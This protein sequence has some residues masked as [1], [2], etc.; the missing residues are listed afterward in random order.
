MAD[1]PALDGGGSPRNSSIDA[2]RVHAR[3]RNACPCEGVPL[4]RR[5]RDSC[6]SLNGQSVRA[7]RHFANQHYRFTCKLRVCWRFPRKFVN[8]LT[9]NSN[10]TFTYTPDTSFTGV[11]FFTYTI[12]DGTATSTLATARITVGTG[13]SGQLNG[14]DLTRISRDALGSGSLT[15]AQPLGGGLNLVYQS[16]TIPAV[17]VPVETFLTRGTTI[18]NSA[19]A[20]L[21][22]GGVSSGEVDYSIA[23]RT[24]ASDIPAPHEPTLPSFPRM[25]EPSRFATH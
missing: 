4:R 1:F 20:R 8:S 21:T 24:R 15:V 17:L 9:L 25:Q 13:L 7:A 12:S 11:D 18:P 22:I 14:D 16:D 5:G 2:T 19:T 6:A 3:L 23:A 10:G